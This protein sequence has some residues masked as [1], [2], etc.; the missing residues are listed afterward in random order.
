MR[1]KVMKNAIYTMWNI[2]VIKRCSY[3]L[4]FLNAACNW[5]IFDADAIAEPWPAKHGIAINS[6]LNTL[7]TASLYAM[8]TWLLL[9]SLYLDVQAGGI[10][11]FKQIETENLSEASPIVCRR[12]QRGRLS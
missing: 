6:L 1:L 11:S 2:A 9:K 3:F 8:N 12:N 5:L 7:D 4:F 10:G